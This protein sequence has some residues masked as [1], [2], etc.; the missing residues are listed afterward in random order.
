MF[1]SFLRVNPEIILHSF[2]VASIPAFFEHCMTL[3]GARRS[4]TD[5]QTFVGILQQECYE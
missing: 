3:H 5:M 1:Q 2:R 4:V